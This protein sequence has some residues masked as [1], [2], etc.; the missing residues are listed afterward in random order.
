MKRNTQNTKIHKCTK[1]Q[2]SQSAFQKLRQ[3]VLAVHVPAL[4]LSD[5]LSIR[6]GA[7]AVR[8]SVLQSQVKIWGGWVLKSNS[9]DGTN[10]PFHISES[11]GTHHKARQSNACKMWTNRSSVWR[12]DCWSELDFRT[13]KKEFKR[14]A[15]LDSWLKHCHSHDHIVETFMRRALLKISELPWSWVTLGQPLSAWKRKT[16]LSLPAEGRIWI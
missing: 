4:Q 5:S 6:V 14:P 13:G 11:A 7:T 16:Y 8:H 9:I 12:K 10:H 2:Y 3:E 15:K 1:S